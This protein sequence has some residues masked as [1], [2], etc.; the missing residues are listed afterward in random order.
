[1][2]T[3]QDFLNENIFFLQILLTDAIRLSP[4]SKYTKY[5][6]TNK[7]KF[8]NEEVSIANYSFKGKIL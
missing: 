2:N 5:T 7:R 4:Y 8:H 3:L 1:M 6:V